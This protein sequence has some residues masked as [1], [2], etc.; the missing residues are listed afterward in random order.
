VINV[1]QRAKLEHYSEHQFLVFHQIEMTDKLLTEQIS[2]FLGKDFV[3]TF[4]E[5]PGDCLEPVR[6]RIRNGVGMIRSLGPD[7]LAYAILDASVDH[8]FPVLEHFGEQLDDLEQ[9]IISSP[10]TTTM[11]EI[12]EI[13]RQLLTLRRKI[14]PLRDALNT[15]VRDP[16]PQVTEMTRI[17]LRDC[18]DHVMR[19]ID[20]LEMYRELGSDLLEFQLSSVSYK[21]NEVMRVLTV[22]ATIFIPLTFIAGVYG[23]NFDPSVSPW[24]MPELKWYFGYPLAMGLMG[25]VALGS[26]YFFYQQ[27]WLGRPRG[28]RSRDKAR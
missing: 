17:Y 23:M 13:K 28:R 9:Q 3:I 19:I 2:L 12:H 15:L 27:G 5:E 24:N 20:L 21:I 8:Y 10:E 25:A 4:Q 1:H 18:Y 7:Y 6:E 22:I 26:L 16:V 14:W 11:N